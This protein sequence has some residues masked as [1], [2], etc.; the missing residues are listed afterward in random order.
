MGIAGGTGDVQIIL[1]AGFA[2]LLAGSF[3]MASGE[4]VSMGAQRDMFE[5][6]MELERVEIEEFP[7]EEKRELA[8]IYMTKGLTKEEADKVANRLFGD[9]E[10][11]LDTKLR[12][13][14]G[15]SRSQFGSPWAATISSFVAFT[16]GALVPL[17][18]FFI[19]EDNAAIVTSALLSAFALAVV[20]GVM[21]SLGGKSSLWGGIRMLLIGTTAAAV[22]FSIGSLIGIT[23][24]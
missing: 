21:S 24:D 1:L 12:E 13:E 16:V 10:V 23:L 20:G 2:G 17:I 8:L 7:E 3:S 9:V 22:T 18:S 11:A 6:Q 4:Y 15:L 5:H 19:L 14:M